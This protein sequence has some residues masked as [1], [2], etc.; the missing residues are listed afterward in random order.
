MRLNQI[1]MFPKPCKPGRRVSVRVVSVEVLKVMLAAQD[2]SP[3]CPSSVIEVCVSPL[4]GTEG[5][6]G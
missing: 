1:E 6:V 5:G 2:I 4:G 3:R